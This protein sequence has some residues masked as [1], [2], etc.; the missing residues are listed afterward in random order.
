MVGAAGPAAPAGVRSAGL[1]PQLRC[2]DGHQLHVVVVAMTNEGV[3][4][5]CLDCGAEWTTPA[6]PAGDPPTPADEGNG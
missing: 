4:S 3:R 1:D 6:R 2:L 5:R